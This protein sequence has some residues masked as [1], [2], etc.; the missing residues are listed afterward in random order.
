[1]IEDGGYGID[2]IGS[3][4]EAQCYNSGLW[5]QNGQEI[6]YPFS[7]KQNATGYACQIVCVPIPSQAQV[8]ASN[9]S[10][11]KTST[12]W[13]FPTNPT[14][15]TLTLC[16]PLAVMLGYV[17]GDS[18]TQRVFPTSGASNDVVSFNST[19]APDM[20]SVESIIVKTNFLN[21]NLLG[22]DHFDTLA[23]IANN[24]SFGDLKEYKAPYER[25][26]SVSPGD[27][28]YFDLILYDNE[29]RGLNSK[30]LIDSDITFNVQLNIPIKPKQ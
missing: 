16:E 15:A 22:Q 5:W 30:Y 2:E 12:A 4:L 27:Y 8:T 21:N 18:T 10:I 3:Y 13:T 20:K 24:V 7:I 26:L 29:Y 28:Q 1:V 6:V 23:I 11:K 9:G 14:T 17:N 25:N 19:I